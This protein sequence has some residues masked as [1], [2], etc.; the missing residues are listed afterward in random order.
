VLR[1]R[2]SVLHRERRVTTESADLT[3][4][5]GPN[6]V[7]EVSELEAKPLKDTATSY[8]LYLE[9]EPERLS[10]GA[11]L[12]VPSSGI[13]SYLWLQDVSGRE[14][15]AGC[16]GTV[17]VTDLTDGAIEADVELRLDEADGRTGWS[18]KG[19]LRF[20]PPASGP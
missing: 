14:R 11:K 13:H 8:I 16:L 1:D 19:P 15:L 7:L 5:P 4:S 3:L 20:T 6:V 2:Q 18:L 10:R 12:T 17:E 9:V